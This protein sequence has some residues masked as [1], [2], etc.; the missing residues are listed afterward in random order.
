VEGSHRDRAGGIHREKGEVS[1]WAWK[2]GRINRGLGGGRQRFCTPRRGGGKKDALKPRREGLWERKPKKTKDWWTGGKGLLCL[3]K[4][5]I[6][7]NTKFGECGFLGDG[8]DLGI[9]SH[10]NTCLAKGMKKLKGDANTLKGKEG[11]QGKEEKQ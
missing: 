7:G 1:S 10:L 8:K 4:G 9:L 3:R 2:A 5:G 6:Q 11:D